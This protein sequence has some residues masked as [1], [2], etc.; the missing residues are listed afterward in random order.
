MLA[1]LDLKVAST[2]FDL[3]K[4]NGE[5]DFYMWNLKMRAIL[6]QQRLDSALDDDEDPK[7][8]KEIG[9]VHQ[10]LVWTQDPS[11]TKLIAQSSYI[12]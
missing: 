12:I 10:V 4:F 11:I 3:E 2:K 8:K 9:K 1:V 5:N 6:I 7:A